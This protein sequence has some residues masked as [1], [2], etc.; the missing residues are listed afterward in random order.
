MVKVLRSVQTLSSRALHTEK[1]AN[2]KIVCA[3]SPYVYSNKQTTSQ[4]I[5]LP[6]RYRMSKFLVLK[7][8]SRKL[9]KENFPK[10]FTNA[11]WA[12]YFTW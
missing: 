10:A 7:L 3:L 6:F 11:V 1:T 12:E 2:N 5:T 4:Y 9:T 8:P